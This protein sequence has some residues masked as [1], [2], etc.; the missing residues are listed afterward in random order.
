MSVPKYSADNDSDQ[1]PKSD[2]PGEE[3]FFS[4]TPISGDDP[5]NTLPPEGDRINLTIAED[6]TRYDFD[7]PDFFLEPLLPSTEIKGSVT[8][9]YGA[10]IYGNNLKYF[11]KL[12][13]GRLS[14]KAQVQLLDR[15]VYKSEFRIDMIKVKVET[16]QWTA[17]KGRIGWISLDT[18][19]FKKQ[20]DKEKRVILE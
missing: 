14:H 12:Y 10:A 9:K 18:T 7:D 1:N 11:N 5:D 19:S 15:R 13:I 6:G 16:N 20:F 8:A 3:L 17:E 4:D 2:S